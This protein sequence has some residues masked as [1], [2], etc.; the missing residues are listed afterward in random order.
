MHLKEMI[1]FL[2]FENPKKDI[3]KILMKNNIKDNKLL[4]KQ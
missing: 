3:T 1:V 2:S 4:G